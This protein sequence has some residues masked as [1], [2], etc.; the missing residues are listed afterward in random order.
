MR[1]IINMMNKANNKAN[2]KTNYNYKTNNYRNGQ[3][4]RITI[5]IMC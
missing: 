2:D 4:P 5:I 1:M 3:Q